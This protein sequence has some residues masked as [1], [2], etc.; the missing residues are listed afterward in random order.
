MNSRYRERKYN[1][2]DNDRLLRALSQPVQAWEKKWTPQSNSKTLQ[3][4]KWVKSDRVI[5]FEQDEVSEEEPEPMETDQTQLAATH[6]TEQAESDKAE[7]ITNQGSAAPADGT[8]TVSDTVA[9]RD[10]AD[11]QEKISSS[12][13]Q[14]SETTTA[15]S[16]TADDA[17][18]APGNTIKKLDESAIPGGPSSIISNK[19]ISSIV[20]ED[21]EDDDQRSQTPKLDDISDEDNTN[22]DDDEDNDVDSINDPS[23]HPAL[24]PHAQA[25]MTDD[26]MTDSTVA[27]PQTTTEGNT[28]MPL[29]ED[30][31][32][33]EPTNTLPHPLSQEILTGTTAFM[34]NEDTGSLNNDSPAIQT[35][36]DHVAQH[37]PEA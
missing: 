21:E 37:E 31:T 16:N 1:T 25:H 3:T 4:F 17:A 23:K 9:P 5:E 14:Q 27:T 15:S 6:G 24:A 19:A 33:A 34:N 28:P 2:S 8:T 7:G 10:T 12:T 26:D 20:A 32:M 13:T 35:P 29:L 11:G 30:E 22:A 36:E 18:I